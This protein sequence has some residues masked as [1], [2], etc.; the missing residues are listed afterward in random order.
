MATHIGKAVLPLALAGALAGGGYYWW[1][2]SSRPDAHNLNG[3]V[4]EAP[5][6]S[7]FWAGAEMRDQVQSEVLK[8]RLKSWRQ[9]SPR[10]EQG[11]SEWEHSTGHTFEQLL[12]TY[13]ASAQLALFPKDQRDDLMPTG[14]EPPLEAAFSCRLKSRV[15]VEQWLRKKPEQEV[16]YGNF[17]LVQIGTNAWASLSDDC[18]YLATSQKGL[19][20][21]LDAGEKHQQTLAE[22]PHFQQAWKQI[23][24]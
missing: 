23:P 7:F 13:A 18:L 20:V 10:M 15:P 1:T 19:Q 4:Q 22:E 8:Q 21:A 6:S 5:G 24:Q 14:A 3:L 12:D 17:Q 16:A 2:H 9:L 11:L